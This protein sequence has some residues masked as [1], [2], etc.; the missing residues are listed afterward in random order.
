MT[1][2]GQDTSLFPP[3]SHWS[4]NNLQEEDGGTKNSMARHH[5]VFPTLPYPS[6]VMDPMLHARLPSLLLYHAEG[7][8][9]EP[10]P[11]LI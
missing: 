11:T 9:S 2:A 6:S 5:K 7:Q 1:Y 4:R 10:Q 3:E 8:L